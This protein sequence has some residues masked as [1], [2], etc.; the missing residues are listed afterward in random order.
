[1]RSDAPRAV[2]ALLFLLQPL[3][4]LSGRMQLG[5][6]PWR[7]ASAQR[8]VVPKPR[9]L[10]VWSESWR[11]ASD[12]LVAIEGEVR[13]IRGVAVIRGGDF[14]RWDI[15]ARAGPFGTARLRLAVEEHGE[16]RQLLRLRLWPRP[17]SGAL[18]GIALLALAFAFGAKGTAAAAILGA[19]ALVLAVRVVRDCAAALAVLVRA[20]TSEQEPSEG[21]G[22]VET[23]RFRARAAAERPLHGMGVTSFAVGGRDAED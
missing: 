11:S 17:S 1:V 2:T 14:S 4:R 3:A 23:L 19:A 6:T 13:R 21:D 22:V 8:L 5:L 9:T 20:V 18:L 16:G 12:R 10:T 7:S 15:Q